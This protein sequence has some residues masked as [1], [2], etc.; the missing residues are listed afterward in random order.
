VSGGRGNQPELSP[1]QLEQLE[2]LVEVLSAGCGAPSTVRDPAE[3]RSVHIADSLSGLE[4]G[5]LTRARQ[6]A[7]VGAGA[8]LPGLVL[9]VAVPGARVDLIEANARKCE[10]IERAVASAALTNTRTLPVRAEDWAREPAPVGGREA[11][12]LVSA[13]AV[14]RLAT[15]AELASPLLAADGALVAWK[16]RR[17]AGEEEELARA[18]EGLAMEPVEVRWVGPYAGSRNRHLHLIRKRGPTPERLPRRPGMAKKRPFG[19]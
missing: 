19:A 2:R 14:G 10:F 7:D 5:E 13:R 17:D 18:A 11:Y 1:R 16:G 6:I 9:A 4:F 3:V 12:D 8:G 15:L